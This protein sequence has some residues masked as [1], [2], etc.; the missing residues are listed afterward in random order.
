[1]YVLINLA[2]ILIHYQSNT[3]EALTCAL[4]SEHCARDDQHHIRT[5]CEGENT[6]CT[7]LFDIRHEMIDTGE[8][9]MKTNVY[10]KGCMNLEPWFQIRHDKKDFC[11]CKTGQSEHVSAV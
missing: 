8:I 10:L 9:A 1:M 6:A 7:I 2:I 4:C 11:H 3:I 5:K